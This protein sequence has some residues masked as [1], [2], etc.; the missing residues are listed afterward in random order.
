MKKIN[1][2]S[3][4]LLPNRFF[5][6]I[7]KIEKNE[8]EKKYYDKT[9]DLDDMQSFI[10][11]R[12]AVRQAVIKALSTERFQHLIYSTDYG[13]ETE[14]LVGKDCDFACVELKRRISEALSV[15]ER[16]SRVWN[17]DFIVKKNIIHASFTVDTTFGDFE[18]RKEFSYV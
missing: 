6:D 17:F 9:Y 13:I 7:D 1:I 14:D 4:T 16:I 8:I 10:A 12:K 18:M 11:G 2:T 5:D 15:D 3:S